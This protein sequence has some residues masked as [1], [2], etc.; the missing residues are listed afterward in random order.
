MTTATAATWPTAAELDAVEARLTEAAHA[1]DELHLRYYWL[2][3]E[4]VGKGDRAPSLETLGALSCFLE[5]VDMDL[6]SIQ[7]HLATVRSAFHAGAVERAGAKEADDG[8]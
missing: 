4:M 2:D 5:Y 8:S 7:L 6:E 1:I 3:E